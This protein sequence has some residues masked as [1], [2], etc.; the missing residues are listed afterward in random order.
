MAFPFPFFL[1]YSHLSPTTRG[2]LPLPLV[3]AVTTTPVAVA[4]PLNTARRRRRRRHRRRRNPAAAACAHRWPRGRRNRVGRICRK[5]PALPCASDRA[6]WGPYALHTA[7]TAS[8][9]LGAD[10]HDPRRPHA[11]CGRAVLL[12]Q[13][14]DAR[15]N[16]RWPG[17]LAGPIGHSG[18]VS[19]P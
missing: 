7:H 1:P 10:T 17:E 11:S 4:D 13:Q 12:L 8:P 9:S 2:R 6:T 3:S 19:Q 5:H 18:A 16:R 14:G 15:S